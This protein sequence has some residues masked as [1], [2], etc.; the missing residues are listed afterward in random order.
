M[1]IN[2]I[3]VRSYKMFRRITRRYNIATYSYVTSRYTLSEKPNGVI[4]MY[5]ATSKYT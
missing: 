1:K 2:N 5:I 3:N 4:V